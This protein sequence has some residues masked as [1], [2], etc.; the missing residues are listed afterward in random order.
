MSDFNK[1]EQYQ[2]LTGAQIRWDLKKL[3]ERFIPGI[4]VLAYDE[5]QVIY[6]QK[7]Y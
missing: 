4:I 5:V 7:I 1:F 3:I 6:L 2:F